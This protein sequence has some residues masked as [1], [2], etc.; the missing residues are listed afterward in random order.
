[1]RSLTRLGLRTKIALPFAITAIALLIVGLFSV[2]TARNLVSDTEDIAATYLPSVS[3]ILN[4][5]RDLYQALVAQMTLVD[6]AFNNEPT[7]DAKADFA[8][9]ADQARQRFD[10]SVERLRGTGISEVTQGYSQAFAQ[11][12]SSAERVIALAEAGDMDE[13]RSLASGQT[14]TLFGA[15]R[16]YYDKAGTHADEQAQQRSM[17]AATEGSVASTTVLVITVAAIILS[18]LLFTLFLK[19]IVQSITT[20]RDQL[21]NIAEGEG[22][23]TQRIPVTVNDDLGR[24][25]SSFNKVLENL[26]G[27]IG[28]IQSL[29]RNLGNEAGEL[30]TSAKDNNEGVTRQTDS[31]SMVATAINEMQ[32]AIEEVASN[33][34]TAAEIT[35]DA[36]TKGHN[37]ARII[38]SSSK[39]VR[40][41][42]AQIGKAVEVI[43]RLSADSDNITSVLDVIRGI[44]EQTNLLALNAAIEAAR[45]GEQGRGFAVVADEV[46]T[47]AQRTQQSTEDIQTMITSLQTGVSDVVNVMEIGSQEAGETEK[48]ATEAEQELKAILE[49][50][51]NIADMNTS[52]ASATEEQTQVVDEINRNITDINDLA[53]A[54]AERSQAIDRISKSLAQYASELQQ[55]TGRFRV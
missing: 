21:D 26:Q 7:A 29:S 35:R 34:S 23:L 28:S 4:G 43:R 52:V 18:I 9:N 8:E 39:Q 33:A 46:R 53:T 27:M 36:E 1:M 15:L 47:L 44:A 11:W 49:A 50:I 6:Q 24:L 25:A 19:L 5:D 42:A 41:L 3:E 32:S 55:Q 40:Q 54:S 10:E 2:S 31:I 20:L 12:R 30:A 37:S 14:N 16:D 38:H 13:A 17:E 51:S 22:D 48:L 45:A